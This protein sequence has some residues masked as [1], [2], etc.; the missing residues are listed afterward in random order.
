VGGER[1]PQA[2]TGGPLGQARRLHRPSHRPLNHRLVEMVP[3]PF[4]RDRVQVATP[5]RKDELPPPLPGRVRALAL[6]CRR[7]GRPPSP[8]AM[9]AAWSLRTRSRCAWTSP[10]A[11][12]ASM[13]IRSFAPLALRTRISPMT[14][15]RSLTRS[16]T[17]SSSRSP[18]PYIR[19][20]RCAA[21]P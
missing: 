12:R 19:A 17:A 10:A 15:S 21:V 4:V 18:L 14:K 2:V 13:V 6:E 20:P 16:W 8:A 3:A 1:M 11:D 9:S 5:S 7:E